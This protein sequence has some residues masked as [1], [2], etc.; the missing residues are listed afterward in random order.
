MN[1]GRLLK[2]RVTL[3]SS[4]CF[5]FLQNVYILTFFKC[6]FLYYFIFS[7]IFFLCINVFNFKNCILSKLLYR[8]KSLY[9]WGWAFLCSEKWR[10]IFIGQFVHEVNFFILLEMNIIW[11][12]K[13][14]LKRI[15]LNLKKIFFSL[16]NKVWKKESQ[17]TFFIK[18]FFK[19]WFQECH[20]YLFIL[21]LFSCT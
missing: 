19:V 12:A 15:K 10:D 5:F 14:N 7:C 6:F 4:Q 11:S 17:K 21:F 2:V 9:F 13:C 3:L 8:S 16:N 20:F 18:T 1:L